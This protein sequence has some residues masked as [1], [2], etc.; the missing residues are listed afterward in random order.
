VRIARR[1]ETDG[2][3]GV[4]RRVE[5]QR[6]LV[7]RI[8]P[9]VRACRVLLLDVRSVEQQDAREVRRAGGAEDRPAETLPTSNGRQPEWSRCA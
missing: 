6:R 9:P 7:L 3:L 8:A 5:R 2:G 4:G 1:Q